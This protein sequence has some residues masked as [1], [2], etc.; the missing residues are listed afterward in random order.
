MKKLNFL[1]KLKQERKL[2]LVEPS[3]EISDSYLQKANECLASAK[4]LLTNNLLENSIINSYYTMYNSLLSLLF[5]TGI[6]SENH[7]SSIILLEELFQ[8]EDLYNTISK[9]KEERIDKQYYVESTANISNE[10]SQGLLNNSE[11]FLTEIK[12]SIESLNTE[13]INN[14]RDKF[15][16]I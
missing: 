2:E 1:T 9:A 5:K 11:D 16:E 14:F 6:K 4:L 13:Q 12:L 8:K 15:K 3:E 10:S 7:S